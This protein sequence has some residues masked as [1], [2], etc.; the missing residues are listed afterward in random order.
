ML[1]RCGPSLA[2]VHGEQWWAVVDVG[3]WLSTL[4][5]DGPSSTLVRDGRPVGIGT[6]WASLVGGACCCH[7]LNV[8]YDEGTY[9]TGHKTS[10]KDERCSS[11]VVRLPRRCPRRGT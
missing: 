5:R 10:Y 11:F 1:V 4:V 2:L 9:L 8:V 6:R 3:A 7:S